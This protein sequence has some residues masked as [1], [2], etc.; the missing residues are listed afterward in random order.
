MAAAAFHHFPRLR[1]LPCMLLEWEIVTREFEVYAAS[2]FFLYYILS[3]PPPA[4]HF[5]TKLS[6][7]ARASVVQSR[8]PRTSAFSTFFRASLFRPPA[9]DVNSW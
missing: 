3:L 6:R 1:G 7:A 9:R 4:G 8:G 5:R 2:V